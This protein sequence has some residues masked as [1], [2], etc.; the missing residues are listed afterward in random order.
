MGTQMNTK[1]LSLTLVPVVMALL[2][3]GCVS[4]PAGIP[5]DTSGTS[6]TEGQSAQQQEADVLGGLGSELISEND[7]VEIGEMV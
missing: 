2:V 1:I 7:T 4:G 5:G 6:V 3:S